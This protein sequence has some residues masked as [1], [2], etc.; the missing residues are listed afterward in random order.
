MADARWLLNLKLESGFIHDGEGVIGTR[1]QL[2][3][4]RIDGNIIRE[5]RPATGMPDDGLPT[6][7]AGGLLLLPGFIEKHCHL[8]KTLLGDTWQAPR[9]GKN[10][11]QI[12][13]HEAK[14]L[15]ML[16][17]SMENRTAKLIDT[18]L[19]LGSTQI[20]THVDLYPAAGLSHLDEVQRALSHHKDKLTSEIV[21][22]PQHGLL[23]SGARSLMRQAL[24]QGATLV[25]G[26][27]P[28]RIDN[29]IEASLHT[30]MD[31]AV[32]ADAG[33]DLHLHDPGPLGIFTIERLA[34]MVEDAGWQ[35][36]VTLSHAYCLGD[37]SNAEAVRIA[38]KLAAL[39]I[40]LISS[41]PIGSSMPPVD[42][43]QTHGVRVALGS[44]NIFDLWGPFGNGDVLAKANRL[45][46]RFAWRDEYRL[47]RALGYVT[48]GK[49]PLDAQG[50]RIWPQ[51]GDD[52]TF[53]L[54]AASCSAEAV[55]RLAPRRVVFHQGNLA[56]GAL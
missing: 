33:I 25:G 50:N 21:A 23:R 41:V 44:D 16:R 31:L 48:G 3:H 7:D 6:Q 51:V 54:V 28:A 10:R 12:F 26:V 2:C 52:A 14:T 36:R 19:I 9:V 46:E 43:M 4:I 17:T 34:A 53:V 45:A 13:E 24:R 37:V 29:D 42:L 22:F 39:D 35:G 15:P 40:E 27:D 32:E 11:I 55:A 30:M 47:S 8:D 38:D 1:T 5:I 20:R 56:A 18:L 49:M